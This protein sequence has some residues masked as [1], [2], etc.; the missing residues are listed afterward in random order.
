MSWSVFLIDEL[1]PLPVALLGKLVHRIAGGVLQDHV[2]RL[3][4]H[5]GWLAQGLHEEQADEL[6][7]GL[8][9]HDLHG[10]KKR[11]DQLIKIERKTTVH[12]ALPLD[13]GIHIPVG[14]SGKMQVVPWSALTVVS[15]GSVPWFRQEAVV[16]KRKKLSGIN[17][18]GTL[19]TGIPIPSYKT[20]EKTKYEQIAH[21]GILVQLVFV[22]R[23]LVLEIRPSEF[24]YDYL[25][26]RRSM[27]SAQNFFILL[28]DL[29][30]Y[31]A[32]SAHWTEI[33]RDFLE[34]GYLAHAFE[35]EGAFHRFN[36]WIAEKT[37]P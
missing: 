33:S 22:E 32:E 23:G 16:E 5:Y 30:R 13:D 29:E 21:E 3:K 36:L 20:V 28:E 6:L 7:R 18:T 12:Q 14:R 17:L 24:R 26:D 27:T 1:L 34:T 9:T 2:Q 15:I 19:L 37:V 31:T 35:N 25:G 4:I 11:E 10:L 8:E